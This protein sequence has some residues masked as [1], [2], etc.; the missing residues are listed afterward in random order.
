MLHEEPVGGSARKKLSELIH[1][2]LEVR[3]KR[4]GKIRSF[5]QVNVLSDY[6]KAFTSYLKLVVFN[7]LLL[8]FIEC[9]E[10]RGISSFPERIDI[11]KLV[12]LVEHRVAIEME[13]STCAILSDEC[14]CNNMR[15]GELRQKGRGQEFFPEKKTPFP[16]AR[17]QW[18]TGAG[19]GHTANRNRKLLIWHYTGQ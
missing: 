15:L 6:E 9:L 5:F 2:A 14:N 4:G 11:C 1:K 19:S 16:N 17:G 8:S 12:E 13:A 10:I 18:R 3:K 7:N